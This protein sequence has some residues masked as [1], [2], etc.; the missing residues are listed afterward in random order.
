VKLN[1]DI[2]LAQTTQGEKKE[3]LEGKTKPIPRKQRQKRQ[4]DCK[5]KINQVALYLPT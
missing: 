2:K 3:R 4:T 5:E 1:H